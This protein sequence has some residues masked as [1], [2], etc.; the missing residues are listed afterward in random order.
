M[1]NNHIE[2]NSEGNPVIIVGGGGH[3]CVIA[4]YLLLDGREIIGFAD[5]FKSNF[6]YRDIKILGTDDIVLKYKKNQVDIAIG[7]GIIPRNFIRKKIIDWYENRGYR[8]IKVIASDTF[9]SKS[10]D[11]NDGVQLLAGSI[12]QANASIGKHSIINTNSSVDHNAVIGSH[13][14]IAP[15]VTICGDVHIGDN[16]F[17]GSGSTIIEGIKIGSNSFI[18]AGSVILKDIL[19]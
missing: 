12:I 1:I 18:N 11:L 5:K 10:T 14:H 2:K 3:G 6:L 13:C 17:I 16:V 15:G 8:I 9:V 7:L 19:V 4:D